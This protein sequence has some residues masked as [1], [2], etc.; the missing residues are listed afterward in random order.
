MPIWNPVSS[1]AVV[2]KALKASNDEP[3]LNSGLAIG[4]LVVGS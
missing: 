3:E 1:S 2:D 4:R